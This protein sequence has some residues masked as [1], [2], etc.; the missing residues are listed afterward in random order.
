[1]VSVDHFASASASVKTVMSSASVSAVPVSLF[2]SSALVLMIPLAAL[3]V[4]A[5]PVETVLTERDQLETDVPIAF[6]PSL[7]LNVSNP[8]FLTSKVSLTSSVADD[9][10]E[11]DEEE[12]VVDDFEQ[13]A[14]AAVDE[15]I[16]NDKQRARR[17]FLRLLELV[18]M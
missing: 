15:S 17:C 11:D 4:N 7:V 10:E 16:I 14:S 1:M 13:E 8:P 2:H 5:L 12:S 3:E 6:K 9:E 18:F